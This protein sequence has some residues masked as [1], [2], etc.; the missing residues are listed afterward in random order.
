[1]ADRRAPPLVVAEPVGMAR[2]VDRPGTGAGGIEDRGGDGADAGLEIAGA[3]GQP[4]LAVLGELGQQ[5]STVVGVCAV[6][7]SIATPA[8]SARTLASGSCA[9]MARPMFVAW[10]GRRLPT[11][12]LLTSGMSGVS[13]SR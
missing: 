9:R 7:F 12:T 13:R 5:A 8:K 10:A 3:P 2:D 4:R 11:R 1:M 6:T